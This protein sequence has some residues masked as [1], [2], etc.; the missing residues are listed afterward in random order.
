MPEV[1]YGLAPKLVCNFVLQIGPRN[2]WLGVYP[3]SS[4]VIV[5]MEP[6]SVPSSRNLQNKRFIIVVIKTLTIS[7]VSEIF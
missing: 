2:I 6:L 1:E 4:S 5:Q 7:N 3:N